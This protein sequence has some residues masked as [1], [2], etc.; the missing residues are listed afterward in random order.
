VQAKCSLAETIPARRMYLGRLWPETHAAPSGVHEEDGWLHPDVTVPA[1]SSSSGQ[2]PMGSPRI[3][4][5]C[6]LA[7]SHRSNFRLR[8]DD[9]HGLGYGPARCG[10]RLRIAACYLVSDPSLT[11]RAWF[12]FTSA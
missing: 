10:L 1:A 4:I 3:R 11:G 8:T 9:D 12:G 2:N 7:P 6:I 5:N